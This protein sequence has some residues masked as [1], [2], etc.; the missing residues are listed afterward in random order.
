MRQSWEGCGC[1]AA[2]GVMRMLMQQWRIVMPKNRGLGSHV[3]GP[4]QGNPKPWHSYLLVLVPLLTT[5]SVE[6]PC[7]AWFWTWPH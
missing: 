7:P 2:I 3:R 1:Y 4:L 6:L 5:L